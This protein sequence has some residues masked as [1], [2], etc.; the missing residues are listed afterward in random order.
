MRIK[1]HHLSIQ[2]LFFIV[3]PWRIASLAFAAFGFLSPDA[4]YGIA[5]PLAIA[6][7]G[8]S[9]VILF[10]L[11]I[12]VPAEL[13]ADLT[14][15]RRG[16]CFHADLRELTGKKK[17]D[18]QPMIFRIYPV[19]ESWLAKMENLTSHWEGF[20][21]T[22]VFPAM[23]VGLIANCMHGYDRWFDFRYPMLPYGYFVFE[24]AFVA[25]G[26]PW[27]LLYTWLNRRRCPYCLTPRTIDTFDLE[28]HVC[29]R[30]HTRFIAENETET[31]NEPSPAPADK[32]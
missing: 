31:A 28:H 26:I 19:P 5:L 32:P 22:F 4:F 3:G 29:M 17:K 20:L 11:I 30:C 13:I 2:R 9:C 6:V 7:F 24:A 15:G 14:N 27:H 25:L 16:R 12:F 18:R 1:A 21:Q 8:F 10:G 23:I